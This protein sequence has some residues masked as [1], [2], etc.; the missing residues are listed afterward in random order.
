MPPVLGPFRRGKTPLFYGIM[1]SPTTYY[2]VVGSYC[3]LFMTTTVHVA[4]VVDS[5]RP[6]MLVGIAAAPGMLHHRTRLVMQ[7]VV[8]QPS[9]LLP[10]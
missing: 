4:I 3:I 7:E 5:G 9:A 2:C 10:K 6:R 8:R 1:E